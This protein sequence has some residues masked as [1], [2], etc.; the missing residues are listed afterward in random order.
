MSYV[1]V[2]DIAQAGLKGLDFVAVNLCAA[3]VALVLV[4]I[5]G[6][7]AARRA[8]NYHLIAL[9]FIVVVLRLLGGWKAYRDYAAARSCGEARVVEGVVSY[10]KPVPFT[11][12]GSEVFCV[13]EKCFR[14]SDYRAT[15]GFN[16]TS[17]HGGP[18]RLGLP[19]R[20]TYVGET[21]VKLEI[22]RCVASGPGSLAMKSGACER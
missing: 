13:N 15:P 5:F 8:R 4:A 6:Y 22:A 11:G 3:L 7:L 21:I 10:F 17:S 14:Y 20:V 16:N 18:I 19:V 12:H 1:V 9:G 2:F